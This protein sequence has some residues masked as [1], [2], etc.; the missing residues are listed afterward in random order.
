MQSG[1]EEYQQMRIE[2]LDKAIKQLRKDNKLYAMM[3]FQVNMLP[4]DD[5]HYQM[6]LEIENAEYRRNNLDPRDYPDELN[7]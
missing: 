7:Y 3:L 5:V 4:D 2:T 6:F 1:I